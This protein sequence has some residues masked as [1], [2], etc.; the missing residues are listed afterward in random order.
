MKREL[1]P[2]KL[3]ECNV[4][5]TKSEVMSALKKVAKTSKPSQKRDIPPDSASS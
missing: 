4:G 2:S 3:E 5:V 1:K